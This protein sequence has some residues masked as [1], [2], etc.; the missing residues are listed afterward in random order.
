MQLTIGNLINYIINKKLLVAITFLISLI[1]YP[2]QYYTFD[3]NTSQMKFIIDNFEDVSDGNSTQ[4]KAINIFKK[5]MLYGYDLINGMICITTNKEGFNGQ[6]LE[7]TIKKISNKD[8]KT[9]EASTLKF[10]N[11][12]YI[13]S[14]NTVRKFSEDIS[15]ME[16]VYENRKGLSVAEVEEIINNEIKQ[17]KYLMINVIT[18]KNIFDLFRFFSFIVLINS[19]MIGY[20]IITHPKMKL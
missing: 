18:K 8:L 19:L 3:Q 16:S 11:K 20:L 13:L 1:L 12:E 15:R 6:N 4:S 10:I 17:N 14:L 9:I 7:C 5:R 2:I